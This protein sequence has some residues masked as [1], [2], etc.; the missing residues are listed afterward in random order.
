MRL[1]T[2]ISLAPNV[3]DGLS[4]LLAELKPTATV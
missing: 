4:A 3:V 2:G 1:F